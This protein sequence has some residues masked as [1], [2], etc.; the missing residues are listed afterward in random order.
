MAEAT[1][2]RRLSHQSA[3]RSQDWGEGGYSWEGQGGRATPFPEAEFVLW[4][5]CSCL[6]PVSEPAVHLTC[7]SSLT[8][9]LSLIPIPEPYAS[10]EISSISE[11]Q[12][13][14]GPPSP[15]HL[16]PLLIQLPH[17]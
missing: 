9:S 12:P 13:L 17:L 7:S 8:L 6:R 1:C 3:L 10:P 14:L 5:S 11:P 4:P 2:W 15:P 16:S